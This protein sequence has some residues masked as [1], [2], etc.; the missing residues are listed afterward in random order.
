MYDGKPSPESQAQRTRVEEAA[1][2]P[3][4]GL[5]HTQVEMA[6]CSGIARCRSRCPSGGTHELQPPR[7]RL[8]LLLAS[9]QARVQ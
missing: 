1:P 5:V 3:F 7:K 6:M 4:T 2:G 9:I 8:D